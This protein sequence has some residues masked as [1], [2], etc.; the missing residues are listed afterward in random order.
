MSRPSGIIW[1]H[2]CSNHVTTHF[3]EVC[4]SSFERMIE[5]GRQ[6]EMQ[7]DTSGIENPLLWKLQCKIDTFHTP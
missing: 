2:L 7:T 4:K 1:L 5:R 3:K 6:T